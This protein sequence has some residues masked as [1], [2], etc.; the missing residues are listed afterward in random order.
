MTEPLASRAFT[1]E[2]QRAFALMSR[3]R[4]PIH[5]DASFARRTQA[6]AAI[7]HGIHTLLWAMDA[8]LRSSSFDIQSIK[9]R[10]YSRYFQMRSRRSAFVAGAKPPSTLKSSPP[11]R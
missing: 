6:G 4:N 10:F 3:D 2:D 7:V 8:A 5:L 9:V 11:A 1:I